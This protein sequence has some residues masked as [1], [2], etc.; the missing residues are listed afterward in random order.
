MSKTKPALPKGTRDFKPVDIDKR[1]FIFD[2]IKTV[3]HRFGYR[4]LE[5]PSMEL[6]ETLRGKYGD[7][8]DM[9]LFN[10]LNSGDY[11]AKVDQQLLENR[12]YKRLLSGISKR[13]LR[14]DLTV[15]FARFV[16][17]HHHE[18][19]FPFR[20][21]Q[22]QPVWRAD[23]PQK[24]R[25]QEFYQCDADVIGSDNLLYEAEFIHI[26]DQVFSSLDLK[27]SIR[28]N[29]RKLLSGLAAKFGI[30]DQFQA[31]A[32]ALDKM[33]K[34]GLE[35]VKLE[36]K[37]RGINPSIMDTVLEA[38]HA[39]NDLEA[40]KQICGEHPD[41]Y[42]AVAELSYITQLVSLTPMK[43]QWKIDLTLA[44]GLNYYTGCIFEV[45]CLETPMGSLG[46]GGRYA[47][48]T[49]T[50]GL[51][52]MSG[53]G[54]SFGAE[55]IFDVLET[56]D[57]WP[58]NIVRRPLA[59]VVPAEEEIVPYAFGLAQKLRNHGIEIDIYP[60]TGKLKKGLKYA[61]DRN[62][63]YALIAGREEWQKEII[64]VKD[65][66]SGEQK[67]LNLSELITLLISC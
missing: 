42:Q 25:Y 7:E 54:I 29:H 1:N 19:I 9:L 14:Y 60:G 28:V 46:G 16:A 49:E 23:R 3:F 59:L 62:F 4:A 11:L 35:G 24:G 6:T 18:L 17:M 55:R 10:I 40:I 58:K 38:V 39:G 34:I 2:Q 15:P 66:D 50:F 44:R 20:R 61:G 56:L 43:N 27:V 64:S 48:L 12:D 63:R 52:G 5:T 22:I 51:Q 41:I 30:Q 37:N 36:L 26:Y 45:G 47:N 13:A 57:R 33:D 32:V 21:Y 67:P 31:F 65:L 53:V 8:G